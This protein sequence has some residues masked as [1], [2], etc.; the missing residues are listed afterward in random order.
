[1]SFQLLYQLML[2]VTW[3]VVSSLGYT[4]LMLILID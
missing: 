1:M 4:S 2:Q 3:M